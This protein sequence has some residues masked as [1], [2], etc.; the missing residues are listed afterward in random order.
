MAP[1]WLTATV[2]H[3]AVRRRIFLENFIWIMGNKIENEDLAEMQD[4]FEMRER[5]LIKCN[6]QEIMS[7][8][9]IW[10]KEH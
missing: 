8:I 5:F 2:T 10:G 7:G 3:G 4:P 9:T 1:A 6:T